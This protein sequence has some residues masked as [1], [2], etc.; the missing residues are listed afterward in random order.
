MNRSVFLFL[1]FLVSVLPLSEGKSTTQI[2]DPSPP[3]T[4]FHHQFVIYVGSR[5]Y[6]PSSIKTLF[7][8]LI[9]IWFFFL[10]AG[11]GGS[12][13]GSVGGTGRCND[14]ITGG[15]SQEDCC[16]MG[17]GV[18]WTPVSSYTEGRLFFMQYLGNGARDCSPCH[19]K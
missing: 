8:T 10:L 15:I 7:L 1:G 11:G 13:W 19:R 14:Y 9:E 12:C 6:L 4:I 17:A 5:L 3:A 16:K 18:G 2:P